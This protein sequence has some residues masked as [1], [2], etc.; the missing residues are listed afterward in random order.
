MTR[1][2]DRLQRHAAPTAAARAPRAAAAEHGAAQRSRLPGTE[3][4][5]S[6]PGG[7]EA[8]Q[9]QRIAAA[10]GSPV[11][12]AAPEEEL[13]MKAAPVQRA[14]EEEMLQARRDPTQRAALEE[15]EPLQGR[16][17]ASQRAEEEEPLQ[18]R[19]D[20]AQ[21]AGLEDEE[22][23]QGQGLPAGAG[24]AAMPAPAGGLPPALA[25]GVQALADVDMGGVQV[26]ADSPE[27]AAL[28][29]HAFAQ[30]DHIHLA[31]GQ[32][33]HLPHEAWHVA[34]QRQGRVQATT[35]MAGVAVNDNPALEAEADAMGARA[36]QIGQ[37]ERP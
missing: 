28:G 11:Q 31:P 12:R 33:Q 34:Q 4:A 6:A 27:P 13:Q 36:L 20:P 22:P 26:H 3:A 18:G 2:S 30:G 23:L 8:L 32:A 15:E 9:R 7:R 21:R 35:Q 25:L 14:E 17:G 16:F 29:A 5:A 19:L 1:S 37:A 24:P 10:F